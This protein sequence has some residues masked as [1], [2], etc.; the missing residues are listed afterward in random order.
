MSVRRPLPCNAERC[1][2]PGAAGSGRGGV[3]E[4]PDDR[5]DGALR[6]V[7]RPTGPPTTPLYLSGALF[8][9]TCHEW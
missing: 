6:A 5:P 7:S 1:D 3:R 8:V 4:C 2:G 9:E